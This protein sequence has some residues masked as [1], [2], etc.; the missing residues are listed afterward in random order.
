ME[1]QNNIINNEPIY[2]I[3]VLNSLMEVIPMKIIKKTIEE[4][5]T[6][7][8][9]GPKKK[10]VN[11][12]HYRIFA[13]NKKK[14]ELKNV[15]SIDREMKMINKPET[16]RGNHYLNK[17]LIQ[18]QNS[19]KSQTQRLD[20]LNKKSLSNTNSNATNSTITNSNMINFVFHNKYKSELNPIE[21][22]EQK[23]KTNNKNLKIIQNQ[24]EQKNNNNIISIKPKNLFQEKQ[25]SNNNK[26]INKMNNF[27]NQNK[28][29]SQSPKIGKKEYKKNN[30]HE[31]NQIIKSSSETIDNLSMNISHNIDFTS[32]YKKKLNNTLNP[33]QLSYNEISERISF[34]NKNISLE[35]SKS[36]SSINKSKDS[37]DKKDK[38]NPI[39]L[40]SIKI[41]G[42][43]VKNLFQREDIAERLV[44]IRKSYQE[45]EIHQSLQN[46]N[47][48]F[49][50]ILPGNA[51]YLV[52]NCMCHRTSWKEPFSK[53]SSLYNFK[54]QEISYGIEYNSLS[55]YNTNKQI[56]NHYE[57]HYCISNKANMFCYL[58]KYCE[59][60]KISVFKYVPFTIIFKIKE[61]KKDKENEIRNFEKENQEAKDNLKRFIN[62]SQKFV[63]NYNDIGNYYDK[64]YFIK[65]VERRENLEEK[66]DKKKK[67]KK[68][69][70]KKKDKENKGNENKEKENNKEE[71][72][73]ENNDEENKE[74]ENKENE[75]NDD[76]NNE[77]DNK[78]DDNNEDENKE[79][80][81]KE[82]ENKDNYNNLN[83]NNNNN[84][85]NEFYND[86]F[87]KL[88]PNERIIVSTFQNEMNEK[89]KKEK[90][91][92]KKKMIGSKTIIELPKTHETGKHMW[93]V[94]AINLNRGKCIKVVNSFEQIE[95][96]IDKFKFGVKYGF[97]EEVIGEDSE[98]KFNELN[99]LKEKI[100]EIKK[101]NENN[102]D[103]N[104]N[105]NNNN[106][107][108][109]NN[110]NQNNKNLHKEDEKTYLCKKIIIQKYIE[111]PLLYKGRKCDMRIWVLLTHKMKVYVFKEGHLKTCSVDYDVNSK[112][113]F[114]HI[115]NY[116]FQKYNDNFQKFEKGNEV[117]FY[118][119]QKFID[120]KYPNK[121]YNLKVDLMKKVKE[122]V[123]LSMR[124]G[125]EKINKNNRN[126]QFE[127]FG[128]DFMLDNDFNVFLIEIN[129]NPGL[130]ESSP[131]IKIIIPRM[132][133]DALRLT[134][135]QLFDPKYD[136]SLNYKSEDFE[137]NIQNVNYNLKNNIDPNAVNSYLI[138][139]NNYNNNK[140]IN[141]VINNN[142]LNKEE[143]QKTENK[144]IKNVNNENVKNEDNNISNEKYISPF[145]VPGYSLDDNLWE[146]ICDLNE[147][148]PLDDRIEKENENQ[149]F[150]G[151]KHLIKKKKTKK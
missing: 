65:E 99:Q 125:K 116:S 141:N 3:S 11:N 42:S 71:I 87:P 50:L 76:E 133:D 79:E 77:D 115:T 151:I 149:V 132:L 19:S 32:S 102:K 146:F 17:L 150:T 100:N 68:K 72:K 41:K 73:E 16:S 98:I 52:K 135:D 120:E 138:N 134:I 119:F 69:E 101:N 45:K 137:N 131:W 85:L 111:N 61:K 96:V 43:D 46:L 44:K 110:E 92:D 75:N 81:N 27:N 74:E 35:N 127:I 25:L 114:T 107:N 36:S 91:K 56:V 53:V 29:K 70:K 124:A 51:S 38:L 37:F 144:E 106:N 60:R 14:K 109:Q 130:E 123:T 108:N 104:E 22:N 5:V 117:P 57:N 93:L 67:K 136:F 90:K 8:L 10:K 126:Y 12:Q 139:N 6:R 24:E 55:R 86:F 15:L 4:E 128:Y 49:Y 88:K 2:N 48:H 23:I 21:E 94:K 142:N 145:P 80:E 95:K 143:N 84:Q 33:K 113:A 59:E 89:E 129:T 39:G 122:I 20:N 31:K 34:L 63:V 105:N 64:D 78:D 118:E 40:N 148:D 47:I 121:K 18:K 83:N 66:K 140:D 28:I 1:A 58:M 54:W 147:K 26:T 9:S 30:F 62:M 82:N 112:D 7:P 97:S 103:N 13:K